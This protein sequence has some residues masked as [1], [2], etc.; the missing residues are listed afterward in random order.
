MATNSKIEWKIFKEF[1][2]YE[3]SSR[4]D[5]RNTKTG[6]LLKLRIDKDGYRDVLLSKNSLTKRFKVHRIVAICFLDNPENKPYVNHLNGIKSDN[7]IDNL[8]WCTKLENE[9]HAV[10]NDLHRSKLT[11]Q[12]VLKFQHLT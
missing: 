3:V 6:R 9:R 2:N 7:N 5:I 10:I 8:E 4:G 1:D 12:Q 11:V